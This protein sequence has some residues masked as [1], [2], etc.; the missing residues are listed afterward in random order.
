MGK[1]LLAVATAEEEL[2]VQHCSRSTSSETYS[3]Q[4]SRGT[5]SEE[6]AQRTLEAWL[7]ELEIRTAEAEVTF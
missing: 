5:D 1:I 2:A 4:A 7:S 3:W 6:Q